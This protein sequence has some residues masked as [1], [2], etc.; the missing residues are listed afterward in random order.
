MPRRFPEQA[1][2]KGPY[3][4]LT[5]PADQSR[6]FAE[7]VRA[8]LAPIRVI[9]AP[10]METRHHPLT[11]EPAGFAGFVFTS[12]HA[13]TAF[14]AQQPR[15]AAAGE[16]WRGR[17]AWCVGARTAAAAQSAGFAARSAAAEGGD[18]EA[19]LRAILA[20]APAGPLLHLHG[21]HVRVDLAQRLQEAGI[22]CTAA[23]IY[24]QEARALAS[25]ALL[26][27]RGSDPVLVPLFS[28]RSV[29]L[30]L[31]EAREVSAPLHPVAI[32]EATA[33]QWRARRS[34]QV[35]VAKTPDAAGMLQVLE[36]VV[37]GLRLERDGMS[38]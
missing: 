3:L 25:A 11:V 23:V 15:D 19:L 32:S 16:G 17:P 30:F 34:E 28:P 26:A 10:L 20:D 29:A 24:E 7:T 27:L 37:H 9:V 1:L 36:D 2:T 5:R 31:D 8:R 4:I 18:A 38:S 12:Q 6:R 21:A 33:A 22:P 35:A 14:I 13:V